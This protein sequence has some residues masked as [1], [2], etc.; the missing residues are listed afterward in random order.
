M[1]LMGRRMR[2][3][4]VALV[5]GLVGIA[6]GITPLTAGAQGGVYTIRVDA[7]PP[8]GASWDFLRFF[9]G[10]TL[11]V[12]QGDVLRFAWKGADAPH[13]ATVVPAADPDAWRADNQGPG[14]PY[15]FLVPDASLG[16]DDDELDFNPSVLTPTPDC[17]SA[18]T[19]CPFDGAGVANSGF[20]FSAP[21]SQPEFSVSVD[22]PAGDYS[23][24]CLL[25]P[26]M[27]TKLEVV[28]DDVTIPGPG[29]VAT[30]AAAEVQRARTEDG[31]DA[32][33]MSQRVRRASL[34]GGGHR[35]TLNA[36]GFVNGVSA[37]TFV[38]HRV[39]VHVGDRIRFV[40]MPE[41]HTATFPASSAESLSFE[42]PEC[43]VVGPDE[44]ATSPA[45]CASPAD[46]RVAANP[47]VLVPT[48]SNTLRKPS[49][50]VNSGVF[51][52]P[53]KVTFTTARTGLFTFVCIVHGPAMS[54]TIRVV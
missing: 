8:A 42:L 38:D 4:L 11:Q 40:G 19:P 22:A 53:A 10:D 17:G 29:D 48:A 5:A 27:Q 16:G 41:I 43:E 24:L 18:A 34:P 32:S 14:D 7:K 37:N 45:D 20:Q 50:Y 54:G 21:G 15:E 47:Q 52:T 26:G 1:K 51:A 49:R 30:A 36:G 25:H 13:T 28:A 39:R 31:P 6:L 33:A 3:Q 2:V 35:V 12:H 44:P 23:F 9:P 46:F